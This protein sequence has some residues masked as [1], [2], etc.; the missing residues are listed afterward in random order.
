MVS[1]LAK[2]IGIGVTTGAIGLTAGYLMG[3]SS[4]RKSSG[5]KKRRRTRN[6]NTRKRSRKQKQPYTA[7]KRKDRSRKRI[8]YTKN[9]Q[10][11][12]LLANGKARF[13][14]KK[15]VRMSRRRKGGK[16]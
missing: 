6:K 2:G 3:R 13:I 11:Y 5:S 16:Y 15:S 4:S 10:P 8:R 9:N 1:T 14:S 12:V 7:G